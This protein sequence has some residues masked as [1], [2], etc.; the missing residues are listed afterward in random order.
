MSDTPDY[1]EGDLVAPTLERPEGPAEPPDGAEGTR[2][3]H[4]LWVAG[5]EEPRWLAAATDEGAQEILPADVDPEVAYE[6]GA[7]VVDDYV[8]EPEPA[9][10][11]RQIINLGP[12]HPST[13]GV[14]RLQLELEGETIRRVK[15]IIG[16]LHTGM[17]KTAETLTYLQGGTNVTRM[18][19]LSPFHNELCFSLV[20]EQLLGV[21]VPPR[22]Q[23][24]R[25]LM[26]ELNRVASHLIWVATQGMDVGALS[27]MLYGWRERERILA[28]FEKVT[29]LRMNHNYIRPGGVAADLPDGWEED[30]EELLERLPEG[31][32]EYHELLDENP[33]FLDRTVGVGV[34][35]PAECHAYG[36]TG[37]IARASGIAWDL[38]KAFPYSGI[39]RYDFDVPTGRHGDV[40]DRYLV[41]MAE[42][43]ESL[44]IVRQV[45]ETMPAGDY[46]V[47]DAK[48]TPPPRKRIDESMEALIHHFK[49]FTEGF[50]VPPGEAYQA[51]E[52][53]RGE[54][55]MYLVSHGGSKPWRLHVRTPSFA[56][57]QALPVMLTDSLVADLIATLA[58]TDPVLGDVDR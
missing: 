57:V 10:D 16:Y 56:A 32:A 58:S 5:T 26:T 37:P 20:T 44:K 33:I 36:I 4:E 28:F 15:P 53:P 38:R 17:E 50:K 49:L 51:V 9:P 14:L 13:H 45:L 47:D 25:V 27:M 35:T 41:R 48:V 12:Q 30:V 24:I 52:S 8:A 40:Y 54:L 34:I 1:V 2:R 55:G 7:A 31:I 19:Y 3:L 11:E 43:D 29:G 23:A 39:D 6:A 46:R 42:M 22:A 18:D 21:E